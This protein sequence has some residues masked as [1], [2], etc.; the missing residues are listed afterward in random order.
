M[1]I[2]LSF[3]NTAIIDYNILNKAANTIASPIHFR[4][5]QVKKQN[6]HNFIDSK[7]DVGASKNAAE[8]FLRSEIFTCAIYKVAGVRLFLI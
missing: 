5:V 7:C 4:Q 8:H 1:A 6:P 2:I 3:G